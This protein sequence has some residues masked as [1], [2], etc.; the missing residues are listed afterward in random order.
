ML[1]SIRRGCCHGNQTAKG[2]LVVL[3]SASAM[4]NNTTQLCDSFFLLAAKKGSLFRPV[5]SVKKS[6]TGSPSAE[7]LRRSQ[8]APFGRKS[9][10]HCRE[11]NCRLPMLRRVMVIPVPWKQL[12]TILSPCLP[13]SRAGA[14]ASCC[15]RNCRV[16]ILLAISPKKITMLV[17]D[18]VKP[19]R[20]RYILRLV[21][22]SAKVRMLY[23]KCSNY[24]CNTCQGIRDNDPV[25]KITPSPV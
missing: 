6:G 23:H 1:H 18:A 2:L 19:H 24:P 3:D 12:S 20:V 10:K 13:T 11:D 16:Q 21:Y 14:A 8:H 7:R 25:L 9:E 22:G 15:P 4:N 5:G 17:L